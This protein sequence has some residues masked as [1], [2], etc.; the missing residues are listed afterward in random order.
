MRV[1][2]RE[3]GVAPLD[4]YQWR[5]I[6]SDPGFRDLVTR[7]ILGAQPSRSGGWELTA[8]GYVGRAQIGGLEIVVDE[9]ISG[10][11]LAM[12]EVL[13]P[14]A[15]RLARAAS[16]VILDRRPQA[17]LAEMFVASVRSYLS[18][19]AFA[20][21]REESQSGAYVM[22]SLDVPRTAA[23]RA[24]GIRHKVSFRRNR[25]TDDLPL[26]RIAWRALGEVASSESASTIGEDLAASA[27]ALRSAF[28]ES[29][30]EAA[31]LSRRE[32][33]AEALAEADLTGRPPLVAEAAAL[34]LAVLQGAAPSE[35][36]PPEAVVPRSWF[37][38]LENLFERVL[39][40]CI[41]DALAGFAEVSG[42]DRNSPLFIGPPRRLPANPD[43]IVRVGSRVAVMDAKYKDREVAPHAAEI[44]QL[45]CHASALGADRGA[46]F[47]P[48]NGANPPLAMGS[49]S[50]G[51]EVWAFSVDLTRP[52]K[53]VLEALVSMGLASS[54]QNTAA[55]LT[56]I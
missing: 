9:K 35:G 8:A 23:L 52:R 27:R 50:T 42:P 56:V 6:S 49:A 24:R 37:V 29:A 26:N 32:I 16:P 17:V 47:Y 14:R 46:L 43:V 12:A 38:N 41:G 28:G 33:I 1:V 40:T 53:S 5:A 21:Y 19:Y 31:K 36:S 25:L 39:R 13:A 34:S 3:R 55:P 18:G 2:V 30:V 11:F 20:E 7:A 4:G 51:C 48:S 45:L 54:H 44:F 10:G 15:F 22:G